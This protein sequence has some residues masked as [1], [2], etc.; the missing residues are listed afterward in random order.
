LKEVHK[1]ESRLSP[2]RGERLPDE[3]INEILSDT[4]IGINEW[5]QYTT[6]SITTSNYIPPIQQL[7]KDLRLIEEIEVIML[8]LKTTPNLANRDTALIELKKMQTRADVMGSTDVPELLRSL[9]SELEKAQTDADVANINY[10]NTDLKGENLLPEDSGLT[11]VLA[12]QEKAFIKSAR[13]R[14]HLFETSLESMKLF[15]DEG[16]TMLTSFQAPMQTYAADEKAVKHTELKNLS[17]T[18]DQLLSA[19]PADTKTEDSF[20]KLFTGFSVGSS[21]RDA[22]ERIISAQDTDRRTTAGDADI[23]PTK[24]EVDQMDQDKIIADR[25]NQVYQKVAD[26]LSA[27]GNEFYTLIKGAGS[28][29]VEADILKIREAGTAVQGLWFDRAR[30]FYVPGSNRADAASGGDFIIDTL[31]VSAMYSGDAYGNTPMVDRTNTSEP[32]P[33]KMVGVRVSNDLQIEAS[34]EA[35]YRSKMFS[36][37]AKMEVD[38]GGN[39]TILAKINELKLTIE[40]EG[41]GSNKIEPLMNEIKTL[42]TSNAAITLDLRL[43]EGTTFVYDQYKTKLKYMADNKRSAI[44]TK[45]DA[46][47]GDARVNRPELNIPECY[48][49]WEPVS[50]SRGET[51]LD[52]VRKSGK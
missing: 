35:A 16:K 11:D 22:F 49:K 9:I 31:D 45:I 4:K 36:L 48:F 51:A 17:E 42:S 32:D 7:Y 29:T 38:A 3:L 18:I 50:V 47:V 34:R 40:T 15:Y 20:N 5:S 6:P 52:L 25:I 13:G 33:S 19:K 8:P 12:L 14:F 23:I 21:P 37:I 27:N 24:E 2:R 39:A 10:L 41:T 28:T 43:F 26:D 44:I 1:Y 46:L 30:E